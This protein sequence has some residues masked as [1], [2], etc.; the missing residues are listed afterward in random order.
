MRIAVLWHKTDRKRDLSH[1]LVDFFADQWRELGHEVV[2]AFGR[3]VP[4]DLAILHVDLS[5]VPDRYLALA[6]RYPRTLNGAVRDIRKSVISRL[7]AGPDHDGPVI[8]KSDLNC[9]GVPERDRLRRAGRRFASPEDYRVYERAADVPK[10]AW[11]DPAC[12]VERFVPERDGDLY[13]VRLYH[14]LGGRS[15]CSRLA[16]REPIVRGPNHRRVDKV[17]VHDEIVAARRAMGFDFGKFDYVVH[18]GRP[19]LLD[20]NKTPSIPREMNRT[21]ERLARWRRRGLGIL[22]FP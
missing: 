1:Y 4:A 8:V 18:D 2:Y 11:G 20:A 3:F 10:E 14:F 17:E 6:A 15:S 21:P 7:R 13:C 9:A 5:V 19:V 16:S 22:D 12:I